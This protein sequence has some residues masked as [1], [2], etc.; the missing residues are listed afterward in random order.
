M[1]GPTGLQALCTQAV[2]TQ[3]S[4]SWFESQGPELCVF[5]KRPF[6]TLFPSWSDEALD[7]W[8]LRDRHV[9]LAWPLISVKDCEP[10]LSVW[11]LLPT[12][13][14][15]FSSSVIF[16]MSCLFAS[17]LPARKWMC[18]NHK[19]STQCLRPTRSCSAHF[20]I[21]PL[22]SSCWGCVFILF[23]PWLGRSKTLRLEPPPPPPRSLKW[24]PPQL[25]FAHLPALL[26]C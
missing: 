6:E 24:P 5:H 2:A 10:C 26:V 16:L 13:S 17:S 19:L 8:P 23:A 3:V 1:E 21:H 11:E 14:I 4:R 9:G 18:A 20:E 25:P 7:G 22:K 15:I 12:S